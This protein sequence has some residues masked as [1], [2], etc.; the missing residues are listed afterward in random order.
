MTTPK[1]L[2]ATLLACAFTSAGADEMSGDADEPRI[3]RRV[4]VRQGDDIRMHMGD[5]AD[6]HALDGMHGPGPIMHNGKTVKNAPY[7]AEV[8]SERQQNLADGNQIVNKTSSMSY[9]DSAGRTRQELRDPEGELRAVTIHD[10]VAHATYILHPR[11]KSAIKIAANPEMARAAAEAARARL[12]QLRKEGKLPAGKPAIESNGDRIIVKRIERTDGESNKHVQEDVRIR[13]AQG[14]PDGNG[15]ETREITAQLGPMVANAMGNMK[16][17]SKATVKDLGTREFDGVKAQGKLRSYEI[18]AGEVGNRN[19]IVVSSESWYSPEL[20][21][22]VYSKHSDPRSGDFIYRTE[23][24]K[25]EEPAAA[26]F[27][28]PSDYTVKDTMAQVKR[29]LEKKAE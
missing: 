14:S 15:Q 8:V 23:N 2:L 7:T 19:P 12:E 17:A 16:W 25:R 24:L 4:V 27:A 5:L 13:I 21:V 1:L 20:Q 28:V 9:R 11:D 10:P 18:P 3:E 22:T 29:R 26:L 6:L